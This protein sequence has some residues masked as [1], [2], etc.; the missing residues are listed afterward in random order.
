MPRD[1]ASEMEDVF[2]RHT[3]DRDSYVLRDVAAKVIAWCQHND[4]ELLQGW[5]SLRA[6]DMIWDTLNKREQSNRLKAQR[7]TKHA[8]FNRALEA[9]YNGNAQPAREQMSMLDAKFSCTPNHDRKKYRTM[10]S[11]EV[12]H[13]A[14]N[15]ARIE[16]HSGLR[17]AFHE[18]VAAKLLPGEVVGDRFTAESLYNIQ[19]ELGLED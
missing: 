6:Q 10:T 5:L 4:P 18:M 7:S 12:L 14:R 16:K 1:F 13:V 8:V 9:A 19:Y 2:N 3:A 17:R 11:E 15:Y